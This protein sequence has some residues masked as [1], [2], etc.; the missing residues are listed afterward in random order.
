MR[1]SKQIK[2]RVTRHPY[3]RG[4][5]PIRLLAFFLILGAAFAPFNWPAS[6][7]HTAPGNET[8]SATARDAAFTASTNEVLKET[9]EIRE[10]SVLR[11]VQSSAQ[12]RAEIERMIMTNLDHETTPG[13]LHATEVTLKKLG[14]V[15]P[16]FHFRD[17]MV[18]LLTEQVAG[19]YEPKTQ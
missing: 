13:Q 12:S 16:D 6:A 2:L 10:L 9:S 7:Q 18:R 8:T 3:V 11:P 1:M 19:Y 5:R 17:L 4:R 15:P 14:L